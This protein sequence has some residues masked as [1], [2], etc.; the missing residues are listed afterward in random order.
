MATRIENVLVS[1]FLQDRP[2]AHSF[3][4]NQSRP[5][6]GINIYNPSD[7]PITITIPAKE[8]V[9]LNS[10]FPN[11]KFGNV[12]TTVSKTHVTVKMPI[13]GTVP[14]FNSGKAKS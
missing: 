7:A 13:G 8:R 3:I 14:M 11:A 2:G 4:E 10:L 6:L 5:V 12:K 1:A 9:Y